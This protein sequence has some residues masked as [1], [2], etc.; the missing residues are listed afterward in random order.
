MSSIMVKLINGDHMWRSEKTALSGDVVAVWL[1]N[2]QTFVHC[3]CPTASRYII[4]E[5]GVL[6]N[7]YKII[8]GFEL[9]T[10]T[11]QADIDVLKL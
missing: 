9:G 8:T 10:D 5:K 3:A 1:L 2:V 4:I 6:W 11:R 7:A